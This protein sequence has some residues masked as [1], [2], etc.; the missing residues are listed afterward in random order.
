MPEILPTPYSELPRSFKSIAKAIQTIIGEVQ[1]IKAEGTLSDDH[2]NNVADLVDLIYKDGI[3]DLDCSNKANIL[4][5]KGVIGVLATGLEFNNSNNN[6]N[7]NNNISNNSSNSNEDPTGLE[8]NGGR[9]R[10]RPRQRATKK[11]KRP[12]KTHKRRA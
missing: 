4:G 1:E 6:N 5:L 8:Q 12:R 2:Y 7:N 9:R 11:A 3:L 10:R